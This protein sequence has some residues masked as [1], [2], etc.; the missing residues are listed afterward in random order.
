MDAIREVRITEQTYYRW[1]KQ[2]PEGSSPGKL[3]SLARWRDCIDLI[4]SEM[5]VSERRVCRVLEQH[6]SMQR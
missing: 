4:R 1:R 5:K 3:L 6:R 2:Y